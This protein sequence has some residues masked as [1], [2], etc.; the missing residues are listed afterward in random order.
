M[1]WSFESP[2]YAE[3]LKEVIIHITVNA[4]WYPDAQAPSLPKPEIPAEQEQGNPTHPV[5]FCESDRAAAGTARPAIF[6]VQP[7]LQPLFRHSS[8]RYSVSSPVRECMKNPPNPMARMQSICRNNSASSNAPFQAQNGFPR[9]AA[10]GSRNRISVFL[11]I[12]HLSM[13]FT[14]T[15]SLLNAPSG[16]KR[17]TGI[18]AFTRRNFRF[19]RQPHSRSPFS[20]LD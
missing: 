2:Y 14:C 17:R 7:C 20:I 5:L 10:P 19:D 15:S 9:Y 8:P 3:S 18:C 12:S 4:A 6:V 16:G 11:F 1:F 13:N